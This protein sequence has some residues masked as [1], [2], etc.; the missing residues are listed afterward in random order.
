MEIYL[1]LSLKLHTNFWFLGCKDGIYTSSLGRNKD[2]KWNVISFTFKEKSTRILRFRSDERRA[3]EFFTLRGCQRK[4]HFPTPSFFY[5]KVCRG[6][7]IYISETY[8]NK[9]T[10]M[11]RMSR[12]PLAFIVSKTSGNCSTIVTYTFLFGGIAHIA[13]KEKFP[14]DQEKFSYTK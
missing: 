2:I 6:V 5:L 14:S 3:I 1:N 10:C 13:L 7:W 12:Y 9:W 8:L 11:S 4:K